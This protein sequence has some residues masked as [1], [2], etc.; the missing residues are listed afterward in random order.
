VQKTREG[1]GHILETIPANPNDCFFFFSYQYL[2]RAR[3]PGESYE[4]PHATGLFT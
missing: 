1:Q 2:G 4:K 3:I